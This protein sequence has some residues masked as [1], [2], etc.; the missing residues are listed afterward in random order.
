[1]IP[2]K[3]KLVCKNI[4]CGYETEIKGG[5]IIEGDEPDEDDVGKEGT[6]VEYKPYFPPDQY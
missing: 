3:G 5:N 1:M 6:I 4:Y 2:K